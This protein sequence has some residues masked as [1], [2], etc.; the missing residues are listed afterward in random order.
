MKKKKKRKS[1]INST[2]LKEE[3]E[4][5]TFGSSDSGRNSYLDKNVRRNIEG[6]LTLAEQLAEHRKQFQRRYDKIRKKNLK[7]KKQRVVYDQNTLVPSIGY[8]P[9]SR[10][11]NAPKFVF[12]NVP[13]ES[14]T[15]Q[16]KFYTPDCEIKNRKE[17]YPHIPTH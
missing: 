1:K 17:K 7:Q 3:K 14:G 12:S 4:R 10:K 9:S 8:Q 16:Y 15:L 13:R 6:K 5:S 2:L 11:K